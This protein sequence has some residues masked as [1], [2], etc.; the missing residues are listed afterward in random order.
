MKLFEIISVKGHKKLKMSLL[1]VCIFL[2]IISAFITV[3]SIYL[4]PGS[5]I[6]VFSVFK[7]Q[8]R[9]IILNWAP[10]FLVTILFYCFVNNVF[11][12][13]A[14]SGGLFSI[15]SYINLLKIE[16]REDPLVPADI[17]LFREALKAVSEYDLN[18]H[19]DKLCVII[20]LIIAAVIAGYF[21]KSDP[22]KIIWRVFAAVLAVGILALSVRFVY[23]DKELYNSFSVPSEYNIASVFNTLGFNY[24]FLFTK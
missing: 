14:M 17:T 23:R 13:G 20:F 24:C 18:M 15:L 12:A 4:Q 6:E 22:I 7:T 10:V 1:T 3:V 8:P 5:V 16:G 11:Y 9:L 21:I 2:I 19:W